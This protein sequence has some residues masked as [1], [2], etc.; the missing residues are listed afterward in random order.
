MADLFALPIPFVFILG[1]L[2]QGH[3]FC[4]ILRTTGRRNQRKFG[5]ESRLFVFR[6]FRRLDRRRFDR[7]RFGRLDRCRRRRGR[8]RVKPQGKTFGNLL[9][10]RNRIVRFGGQRLAFLAE[11]LDHPF[12]GQECLDFRVPL[13]AEHSDRNHRRNSTNHRTNTGNTKRFEHSLAA[14]LTPIC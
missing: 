11:L 7:R 13:K 10:R 12:L 5:T 14:C 8:R 3:R 1:I 9:Q 4:G 2:Q 6:Q